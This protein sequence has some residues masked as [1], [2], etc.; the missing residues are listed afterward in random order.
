MIFKSKPWRSEKHRRL[1]ASLPCIACGIEGSTQA[2]HRNEGKG[3]GIKA[4]DSQMMPLCVNCHRDLDQGG[5][6]DR[7]TRRTLEL[8]YVKTTRQKMIGLNIWSEE[9]ESAYQKINPS[10]A[11]DGSH[12]LTK[13]GS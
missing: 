12:Q 2:A 13:R 10:V 3:L 8:A 5:K 1:I 7:E 11:A 6:L 4:C 9:V